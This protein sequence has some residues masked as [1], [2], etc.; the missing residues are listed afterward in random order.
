MSFV[1]IAVKDNGND[2]KKYKRQFRIA[3]SLL[4]DEKAQIANVYGVWSHP[5]TFFINREGRIVGRAF[6]G[7][8]WNSPDM[9][10]LIQYLLLGG[11]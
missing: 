2:V 5:V 9:R 3:F 11:A 4:I 1:K 7:K 6:G 10:N 8:D